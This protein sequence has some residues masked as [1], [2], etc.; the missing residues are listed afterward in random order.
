MKRTLHLTLF[1]KLDCSVL[2]PFTLS[3]VNRL[4]IS[5]TLAPPTA[6]LYSLCSPKI[7]SFFRLSKEPSTNSLCLLARD[8]MLN[9]S[10]SASVS[11]SP[12]PLTRALAK[13]AILSHH[14]AYIHLILERLYVPIHIQSAR[15]PFPWQSS[16]FPLSDC[17]LSFIQFLTVIQHMSLH[18]SQLQI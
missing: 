16:C 12:F 11:V 8:R 17:C 5:R 15:F 9:F 1:R 4:T 7:L 13:T 10:L 18:I 6:D 2:L 14:C 3:S